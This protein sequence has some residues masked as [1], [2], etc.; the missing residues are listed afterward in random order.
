MSDR[1]SFNK[2]GNAGGNDHG[3]G[4]KMFNQ[5]SLHDIKGKI[6]QL[7]D[8]ALKLK[9][10]PDLDKLINESMTYL[11]MNETDLKWHILEENLR[12]KK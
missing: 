11:T 1:M 6:D 7:A 8:T 5:R 4:F 2:Q 3:S 9:R 12:E 10:R